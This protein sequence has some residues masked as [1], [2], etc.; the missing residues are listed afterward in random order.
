MDR[1]VQILETGCRPEPKEVIQFSRGDILT[2]ARRNNK[3]SADE[4]QSIQESVTLS[5]EVESLLPYL[6]E[7]VEHIVDNYS[8]YN[9]LFAGRDAESLY[10]V[11]K[12]YPKA[13][14]I[15]N[16]S[17]LF[18]G[19][20]MLTS[21]LGIKSP[22]L[23]REHVELIKQYKGKIPAPIIKLLSKEYEKFGRNY[24]EEKHSRD[25]VYNFLSVYGITSEAIENGDKFL[26]VDTGFRGSIA[27]D[28][29][30]CV[31][32]LFFMDVNQ[33]CDIILPRLV[34]T[35][36]EGDKQLAKTFMKFNTP[37]PILQEEFPKTY[38]VAKNYCDT[39]NFCIAL[40]F[41][42]LPHYH[43]PFH[44][45]DENARPQIYDYSRVGQHTAN[46]DSVFTNELLDSMNTSI[47]NP[48][49][50]LLVQQR[51]VEYFQHIG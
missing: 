32:D 20:G 30:K 12:I 37:T 31:M 36:E 24:V 25:L 33:V 23:F 13:E 19:S 14:T 16:Q 10:D 7:L 44:K 8:D 51:V 43:G 29:M 39:P 6:K 40:A 3:V 45:I 9:L 38:E 34:G 22:K 1:I 21:N 35:W 4:I 15:R 41:Q 50:A 17:F 48:F 11:V 47:V 18:P 2:A 5:T 46:I 27:A 42:L 49:G 28:I 26:V